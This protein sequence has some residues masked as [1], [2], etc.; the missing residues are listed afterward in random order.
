MRVDAD[1]PLRL[2]QR[3]RLADRGSA[4]TESLGDL[5]LAQARTCPEPA[6]LDLRSKL[7]RD[8][9]AGR[10]PDEPIGLTRIHDL[11]PFREGWPLEHDAT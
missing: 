8:R 11:A 9:M 1:Q 7:G 2:K 6:P 10:A 4:Y 3:E 5:A